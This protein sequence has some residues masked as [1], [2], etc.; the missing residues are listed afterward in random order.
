MSFQTIIHLALSAVCLNFN[1]IRQIFS[2]AIYNHTHF[3]ILWNILSYLSQPHH[4]TTCVTTIF[5][6]SKTFYRNYRTTSHHNLTT[7][8]QTM[9]HLITTHDNA[10]HHK[11]LYHIPTSA[12]PTSHQPPT[13]VT[14]TT[15]QPPSHTSER[16]WQMTVIRAGRWPEPKEPTVSVPSCVCVC[17]S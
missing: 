6:F 14:L 13:P 10:L 15:H 16:G 3:L 7:I 12:T 9:T 11:T 17:F 4:P 5:H 2:P 8:H 1:L